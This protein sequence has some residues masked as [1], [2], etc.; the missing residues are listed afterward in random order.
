MKFLDLRVMVFKN[1]KWVLTSQGVGSAISLSGNS[2]EE[3]SS[4]FPTSRVCLDSLAHA[5]VLPFSKP[6]SWVKVLSC[7]HL[8]SSISSFC[9]SG[10]HSSNYKDTCDYTEPPG[11]PRII[12]PS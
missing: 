6:Q 2:R 9:T 11:W 5:S 8:S 3:C 4:P 10:S 12:S 1:A 7:C